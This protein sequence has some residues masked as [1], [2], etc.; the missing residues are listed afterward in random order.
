MGVLCVSLLLARERI[1]RRRKPA[2]M[3]MDARRPARLYA[4]PFAHR[5]PT[6]SPTPPTGWI[7]PLIVDNA[8]PPPA[9]TFTGS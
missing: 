4:H 5:L 9:M 2:R 6:P 8:D 7:D 1:A 3:R